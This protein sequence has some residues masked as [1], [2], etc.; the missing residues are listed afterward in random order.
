MLGERVRDPLAMYRADRL[1]VPVSL[2]GL[3]AISVPCDAAPP[4][5]STPALPIG[6]QF[7]G[8]RLADER[9]LALART[10]Q[11]ATEHHARRAPHAAGGPA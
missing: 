5:D 3:P 8:P 2:A 6:L 4:A 1:T 11:R 10:Y 9:V 7:I